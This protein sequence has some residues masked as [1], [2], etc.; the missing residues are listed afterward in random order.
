MLRSLFWLTSLVILLPPSS[1]GAPAPRVSLIHTAYSA[2][3]LLQD[4]T[5]VCARNP[6]AC[7]ASRDAIVLLARKVET[8]AGI[9]SAGVAASQALSAEDP[10]LGT[11][12]A[13]DLRPE[14][15]LADAGP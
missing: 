8:G 15:A 9:V 14:W 12:T 13:A 4:V 2:R 11:L 1:D 6:E 7:A 3:I 5:R 10:R